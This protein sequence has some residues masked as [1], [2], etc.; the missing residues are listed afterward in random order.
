M[1]T[2]KPTKETKRFWLMI[3]AMDAFGAVVSSCEYL[4]KNNFH[5]A[6]PMHRRTMTAIL[7]LY[8]HP[9]HNNQGIGKLDESIIPAQYLELHNE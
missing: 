4:L 3:Y 8:G 5:V 7:T 1:M 2:M 6:G 9:F